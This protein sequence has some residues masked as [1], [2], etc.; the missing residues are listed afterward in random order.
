[1]KQHAAWY[2]NE[3]LQLSICAIW[4]TMSDNTLK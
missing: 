2:N 4:M 1:M 3:D